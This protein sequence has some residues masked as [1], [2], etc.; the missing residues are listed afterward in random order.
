MRINKS[1]M[2]TNFGDLRPRGREL[3]HKKNLRSR[4]R[5]LRPPKKKQKNGKFWFEKLLNRL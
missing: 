5:E 3:T 4:D 2:C 1:I